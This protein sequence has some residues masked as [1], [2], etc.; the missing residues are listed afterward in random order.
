MIVISKSIYLYC[1]YFKAIVEVNSTGEH[2]SSY[3]DNKQ[4]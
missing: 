2:G 3:I 4:L 1:I